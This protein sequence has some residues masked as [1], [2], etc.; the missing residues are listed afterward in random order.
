MK[1]C[2]LA[3]LFVSAAVAAAEPAPPPKKEA[4][5]APPAPAQSRAVSADTADL[6][7][8]ALP[9]SAFVKPPEKKPDAASPVL[10]ES[11]TPPIDVVRLQKFVVR[12]EKPP[13]FA[14]RD[15]NPTPKDLARL[16][17]RRYF[18]EA[19]QAMNHFKLPLFAVSHYPGLTPNE[20]RALDLYYEDERLKNMA[21]M[22]DLTNMVT[23]SNAAAG[24]KLKSESQQT[25]MRR[26]DF[27][28][29]GGA[30]K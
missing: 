26:Q 24:A 4:P 16:A 14:E 18:K 21:E 2:P 23:K 5:A 20:S 8:A 22:A 28:W 6:L 12:E 7:K 25:F 13:I 27:G 17:M 11:E 9:K 1:R 19:D 10:R 15:L 30:P 29:N 3:L